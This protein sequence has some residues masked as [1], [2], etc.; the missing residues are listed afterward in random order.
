MYIVLVMIKTIQQE[1]GKRRK[2]GTYIIIRKKER[3]KEKEEEGRKK[4][5]WTNERRNERKDQ[6]RKKERKKG[7]KN[8]NTK[9]TQ[10]NTNCPIPKDLFQHGKLCSRNSGHCS[11]CRTGGRDDV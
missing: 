7:R 2:K 6:L 1:K 4:K 10:T 5:G 3:K 9:T 8:F 11:K